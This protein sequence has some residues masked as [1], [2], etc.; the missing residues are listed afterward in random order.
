MEDNIIKAK[1][2]SITQ[3]DSVLLPGSNIV[4]RTQIV[5]VELKNG[6]ILNTKNSYAPVRFGQTVYVEPVSVGNE[7]TYHIVGVSRIPTLASLLFLF[8]AI[9][10]FI[11]KK[12]G[13]RGLLS[14]VLTVGA[15]FGFLIPGILKTSNPFLLILFTVVILT[16]VSAL[17]THGNNRV[18]Y[19]AIIGMS[20]T[21]FISSIL[22]LVTAISAGLSGISDE[23]SV[24]LM[25][26]Q[27]GTLN[28][29]GLFLGAVLI[30]LLGV[31][32]DAAISQSVYVSETV[33]NNPSI[34]KK[35]L[36]QSAMR[37]GREHI[38]ALV[39]TLAIVSIGAALVDTLLIVK[40]SNGPL[41]MI[42]SNESVAS[43][44]LQILVGSIGVILAIPITTVIAVHMLYGKKIENHIGHIH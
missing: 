26:S 41:G 8:V 14:L 21:L 35:D 42:L 20:I 44:I 13:I 23:S 39:D 43:H 11:G 17:I 1:V 22:G 38:G 16:I 19:T 5:N 25:V 3:G 9:T 40:H 37:F 15:I 4:E 10:I 6:D 12:K 36:M 29:Q 2:N 32:Y 28:M 24:Y 27:D 34:T 33:R 30:G 7:N 31:L 18:T